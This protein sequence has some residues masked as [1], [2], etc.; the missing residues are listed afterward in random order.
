MEAATEGTGTGAILEL[1]TLIEA[2]AHP[3]IRTGLPVTTVG[4]AMIADV[5]K[6]AGFHPLHDHRDLRRVSGLTKLM[7]A[8]MFP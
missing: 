1:Q 3:E 2:M 5:E 8:A 7:S 6:T 4:E